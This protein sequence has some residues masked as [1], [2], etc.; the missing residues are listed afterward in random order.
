MV[1]VLGRN[2]SIASNSASNRVIWLVDA[3]TKRVM[4]PLATQCGE[5]ARFRLPAAVLLRFS[6]ID[7]DY[8]FYRAGRSWVRACYGAS[9]F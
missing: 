8:G 9:K 5:A 7:C 4:P 2:R 3:L 1:L 6:W